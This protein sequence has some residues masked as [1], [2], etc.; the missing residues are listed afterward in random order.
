MS[1]EV[2]QTYPHDPSAYTQGLVWRGD[3]FIE[4][5]GLYGERPAQSESEGEVLQ[6]VALPPVYFGKASRN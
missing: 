5:T 4:G 2:L 3:H 6:N 1:Y